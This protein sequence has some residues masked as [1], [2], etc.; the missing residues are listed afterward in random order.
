MIL[1]SNYKIKKNKLI[2]VTVTAH[3]IFKIPFQGYSLNQNQSSASLMSSSQLVGWEEW[4]E[5][6]PPAK[7]FL[8]A[9]VSLT[10][11]TSLRITFFPPVNTF[12]TYKTAESKQKIC[13]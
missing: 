10:L 12:S 8:C 1:E 4:M 13:P 2:L 7:H 6:Y 9:A 11:C 3:Q 5:E